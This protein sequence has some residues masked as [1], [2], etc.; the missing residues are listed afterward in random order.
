[1]LKRS[2]DKAGILLT[3]AVALSA[4]S[5]EAADIYGGS[6]KDAPV[7]APANTWTGFYF[8]GNGGYG[9]RANDGPLTA[10]TDYATAFRAYD[11]PP[12]FGSGVDVETLHKLS[13]EG[14]FGG[15]Q[16]GYNAQRDRF[17]YGFETDI[18]A[19]SISDTFNTTLATGI[20]P[21]DAGA[22]SS[23]DWFGTFRGRLGYAFDRG[24]LYATGGFA[25]GGVKDSIWASAPTFGDSPSFRFGNDEVRAGYTVG[26][27][28]EYMIWPSWS[29][30]VEY[31]YIDLGS[32]SVKGTVSGAYTI[33]NP[34]FYNSLSTYSA[35]ISTSR[36][37][38]TYDTIRAGLNYHLNQEYVPLK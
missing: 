29:L 38:H 8:G 1:M 9:W 2:K 33:P 18:Q 32:S 13:P 21:V 23:L 36:I 5:A 37:D 35:N 17:V 20:G 25:V 28:I 34:P 30:K 10:T 6:F 4:F 16:F 15:G 26:A 14:G 22:K 31:Q 19:A 11:V 24:L 7:Y 3:A 27:G 12:T